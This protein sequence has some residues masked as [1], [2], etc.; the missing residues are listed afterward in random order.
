[1]S[2]VKSLR[3]RSA[4]TRT[5]RNQLRRRIAFVVLTVLP[6]IVG[7]VWFSFANSNFEQIA[8]YNTQVLILRDAE[9]NRDILTSG[10]KAAGEGYVA[11]SG[12]P[13]LAALNSLDP[14]YSEALGKVTTA[15]APGMAELEVTLRDYTR[16]AA[17]AVDAAVAPG[18]DHSA[19]VRAITGSA[20]YQEADTQFGL[21]IAAAKL[22][23]STAANRG[24]DNWK[25]LLVAELVITLFI[26]ILIGTFSLM[27][28]RAIG[29]ADASERARRADR[30]NLDTEPFSQIAATMTDGLMLIGRDHRIVMANPAAQTL[31]GMRAMT[32]AVFEIPEDRQT[33][34]RRSNGETGT[35]T[36]TSSEGQAGGQPVSIVIVRENT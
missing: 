14:G 36:L 24:N 3:D 33:E 28:E 34:I 2:R 31:L 20:A 32:N 26:T 15:H 29:R 30:S 18:G 22:G 7:L 17:K 4:A 1:M 25:I 10:L 21:S 13:M 11:D 9:T 27:T 35:A 12:Q 8:G 16:I 19:A 5:Q 23:S 6:M